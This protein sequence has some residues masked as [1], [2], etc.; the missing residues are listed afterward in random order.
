M[1]TITDPALV[2]EVLSKHN[3]Y[4]KNLADPVIDKLAQGLLKYETDKWSKHRKIVN[5]SFQLEKLIK[6]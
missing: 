3:T 5:P 4:Q 1:V 2:K 6:V